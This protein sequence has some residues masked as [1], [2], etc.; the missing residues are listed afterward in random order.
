MSKNV[1]LFLTSPNSVN[2]SKMCLK[3]FK[4]LENLGYDI[5]TLSTTDL[6]PSYMGTAYVA[7]TSPN[8]RNQLLLAQVNVEDFG[9][10]Y[11]V[12]YEIRY[13]RDGYVAAVYPEAPAA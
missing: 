3:N 4:Q 12:N 1:I 6:L 13:N 8:T 11:K 9:S 5:I 10:L 7:G 2:R